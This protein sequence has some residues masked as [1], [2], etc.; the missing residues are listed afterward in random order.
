MDLKHI[1]EVRKASIRKYMK[2]TVRLAIK[3][4]M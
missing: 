3:R 1:F 2:I 4:E